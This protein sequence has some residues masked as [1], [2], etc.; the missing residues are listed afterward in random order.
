MLLGRVKNLAR[1]HHYAEV[2]HFKVIALQN[3]PDDILADIVDVALDGG[4]DDRAVG[5]L[6]RH[7][8][9]LG[10]LRLDI[11]QQVRNGLFHHPSRLDDLGQE[12]LSGPEEVT[13]DVHPVHQ[14]ALD[15]LDRP[16]AGGGDFSPQ[17]LGV[18]IDVGVDALD[19]G[20]RNPLADRKRSPLGNL[21]VNGFFRAVEPFSDLQ[22]PLGRVRAPIQDDVG[23]P[24]PQLRVDRVVGHQ[25]AGV[26]DAHVQAGLDGVEQEHR[27]HRLADGVIAAE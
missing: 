4:H 9:G 21:C 20:V 18:V 5:V 17:F 24:V 8:A 19:E 27:M 3:N 26:D 14:R 22:Q 13:D 15:H 10:F 1:G 23:D 11:G 12:H 2:D 6:A 7:C 25:R 16:P